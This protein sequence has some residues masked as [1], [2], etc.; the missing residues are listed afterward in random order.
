MPATNPPVLLSEEHVGRLAPV[1]IRQPEGTF[2]L[3]PASLISARAVSEHADV[4][5]G[6]GLDW[7]CGTGC[8]AILA[9]KIPAVRRVIGTDLSESNV[10]AAQENA[11]LNGV[12]TKTAFVHADSYTAV[13]PED[14]HLLDEVMGTLDFVVGNPP[15]SESGDGLTLRRAMLSGSRNLLKRAGILLVQISRHY[16]RERITGL[17]AE[18]PGITFGRTVSSTDWMPFDLGRQD[19]RELLGVYVA[20]ERRGGRA[21]AFGDPRNGGRTTIDARTALS[22]YQQDGT[23]PL[24]QWQVHR[25]RHG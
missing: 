14:Q 23:S 19:L 22:L 10:R 18:L 15:G 20:E 24:T 5:E 13:A 6:V 4:L 2:C 8:L 11:Q 12:A 3:T 21:Y 7:G 16:T 9:A 17:A 1:R 25:F